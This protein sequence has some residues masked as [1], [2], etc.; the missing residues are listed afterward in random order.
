MS[1]LVFGIRFRG[2]EIAQ[3]ALARF[4]PQNNTLW[5]FSVFGDEYLTRLAV[6]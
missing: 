6:S 1:V 5:R 4:W 2:T 3:A